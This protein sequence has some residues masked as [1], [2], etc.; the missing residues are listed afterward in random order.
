MLF[1]GSYDEQLRVWDV[2]F[3][4][5]PVNETWIG[6]GGGVWRIKQHPDVPK[7]LL[8]ACMHNG[9]GLVKV[10]GEEIEVVETYKMHESLAYGAD[11]QR[12]VVGEGG[13]NKSVV[14]TCSFYDRLVRVWSPE[15]QIS[16]L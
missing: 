12:G 8:A 3:L 11:W 14:A 15:S 4:S 7:I 10:G 1:T 16:Y 2:R 5:K 13:R 6:L 9:F